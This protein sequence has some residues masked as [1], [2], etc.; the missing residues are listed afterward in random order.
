MHFN[1]PDQSHLAISRGEIDEINVKHSEPFILLGA[2]VDVD[3]QSGR[4]TL[5]KQSLGIL[6]YVIAGPH[7]QSHKS[8]AMDDMGTEEFDEYFEALKAVIIKSVDIWVHS[9]L[10]E[11]EIGRDYFVEYQFPIFEK[12]L[13]VL[14]DKGIA[15][16]ISS[17]FQR[18]K[19]DLVEIFKLGPRVEGW[20]KVARMTA[21]I[22][23]KALNFGS[24]KFSFASDAHELENVG[25]I[26]TPITIARWLGILG[27][28]IVPLADLKGKHC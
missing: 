11:I 22:Y 17:T 4:F 18:N 25:D 12:V 14:K 26:G 28:R 5:T 19:N 1:S 10:Q 21:R 24:I 23:N 2:E 8:L 16:E 9:F 6:D 13:P 3:H 7:N 27:S 15:M 20:I